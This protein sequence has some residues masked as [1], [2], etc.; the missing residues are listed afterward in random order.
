MEQK[1]KQDRDL[2]EE[3]KKLIMVCEKQE[4]ILEQQT[5]KIDSCLVKIFMLSTFCNFK[6]R[7]SN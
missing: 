4:E 3:N 5:D 2:V 1:E 6:C 7:E